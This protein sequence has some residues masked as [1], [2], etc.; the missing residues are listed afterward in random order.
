MQKKV[1]ITGVLGGIGIALAKVFKENGFYVYGLD[2]KEGKCPYS[3]KFIAFDLHKFCY[4]SKYNTSLKDLFE[5]EIPE[6]DVLINNAAVQIL[7]SLEEIRIEDW[8]LTMNVNL[9]GAMLLSQHFLPK[10]EVRKGSIIN[11]ASIHQQLTKKRFLAYA[12]SKSALVGFTKAL[13]VDLQG[14]VRVNAISPAAIDTPM[15]HEGFNYDMEKIQQLHDLHPTKRFGKP[16]EVAGL[17]LLLAGD[18]L[19]FINGANMEIDGGI[20]NVLKDVD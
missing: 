17:A 7:G 14:K 2:V 6:L 15:L 12:T 18:E 13:S 20:S 4:D 16:A 3:D 19:G 9:T 10:L 5:R 11:I 1:A 8:T